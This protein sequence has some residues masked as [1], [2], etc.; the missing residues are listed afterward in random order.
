[1]NAIIAVIV[2]VIFALLYAPLID[3]VERKIKARVQR[4]KGPPI[5]QTWYDILKLFKK[6]EIM[7]K[8]ATKSIFISAPF[9]AFLSVLISYLFVPTI[10]PGALYFYGDIIV[11][12]YLL[13]F[14]SIAFFLG[15]FSS[16]NP[17]AQVGA[18]REMSLAVVE[19]ILLAFIVG[20]LAVLNR[21]LMLNRMFPLEIKVSSIILL[22]FYLVVMY[23]ASARV[24]FDIAEAEPEI[25]EGPFIEYSG[26]YLAMCKYTIFLKR[27]LLTSLFLNLVLPENV[28]WRTIGYVIGVVII[29]V[30]LAMI[31]AHMGRMRIDQAVRFMKRL[32]VIGIFAWVISLFGW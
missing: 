1:M 2:N 6:E 3:G 9:M 19:E 26:K 32:S 17:Y 22:A 24:P 7:P 14:S 12:V 30:V 27:I 10:L 28:L 13:A 15:A 25:A 18:N 16:G 8:D 20:S 31:E 5:Q 23:I 21:S 29:P 11:V 4:R